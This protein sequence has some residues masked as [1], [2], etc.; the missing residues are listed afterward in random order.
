LAKPSWA[1][2]ME[3]FS[4]CMDLTQSL[5]LDSSLSLPEV[6]TREGGR[7]EGGRE[8]GGRRGR[9]RGGRREGEVEGR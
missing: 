6:S 4:C 3:S 1:A 9:Q 5:C 8:E 7:E 2:C